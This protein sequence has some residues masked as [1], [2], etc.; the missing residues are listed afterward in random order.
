MKLGKHLWER[1]WWST[2]IFLYL[3]EGKTELY[4]GV[5][6][7]VTGFSGTRWLYVTVPG[8]KECV[9]ILLGKLGNWKQFLWSTFSL[10]QKAHTESLNTSRKTLRTLSCY[11]R[12]AQTN[13]YPPKFAPT[14]W[15]QSL[16]R[17]FSK[18]CLQHNTRACSF[19]FAFCG[20]RSYYTL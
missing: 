13:W 15:K 18:L 12:V 9:K 6:Y 1:D 11:L 19:C 8:H 4:A 7:F 17:S 20:F 16:E 10:C 14:R 5:R 3:S 2:H